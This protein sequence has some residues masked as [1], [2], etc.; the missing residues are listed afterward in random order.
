MFLCTSLFSHKQYSFS[1]N[2]KPFPH[3]ASLLIRQ[4]SQEPHGVPVHVQFVAIHKRSKNKEA[5]KL[6]CMILEKVFQKKLVKKA[7]NDSRKS[8][9]VIPKYLQEIPHSQNT[10]KTVARK[11]LRKGSFKNFCK[12]YRKTPV[13]ESLFNDF[14]DLQPA[15]LLKER[16]Y[17]R[18]F[19]VNLVNYFSSAFYRTPVNSASGPTRVFAKMGSQR[20]FFSR[21]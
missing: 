11:V 6:K 5:D 21:N 16:L 7:L 8:L 9:C 15:T 14:V 17:Y 20:N 12:N 10:R 3:V 4:S 1:R 18:Y 2:W 19:P 13:S